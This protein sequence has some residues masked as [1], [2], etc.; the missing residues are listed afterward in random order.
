MK[1]W[2][3]IYSEYITHFFKNNESTTFLKYLKEN[4][5]YFTT[6]DIIKAVEYGFK[7]SYE[8]QHNGKVPIGNILQ[9]IMNQKSILEIPNEF[10]NLDKEL[11]KNYGN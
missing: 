10:K 6:E 2:D 11:I 3:S 8:S 7:Y 5:I 9:W 4:K 1:N